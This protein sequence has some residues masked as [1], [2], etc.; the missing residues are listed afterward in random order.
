[1]DRRLRHG[2]LTLPGPS[3]VGR[4]SHLGV[5]AIRP[6]HACSANRGTGRPVASSLEGTTRRFRRLAECR[7]P[8]GRPVLLVGFSG[9]AAFAGGL[10][11][12]DPS[13]YAGAAILY[14]T[15]P[16]TPCAGRDPVDWRTCRSSS[17][18]VTRTR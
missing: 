10:V 4:P 13:R 1:M 9:G 14:G 8:G 7:R 11:L 17:P 15:L 18:R 12:D 6:R 3:H 5:A 16:L 2:R